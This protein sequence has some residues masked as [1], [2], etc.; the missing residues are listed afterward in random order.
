[1]NRLSAAAARKLTAFGMG[2]TVLALTAQPSLARP[3]ARAMTCGQ[4]QA[5]IAQQG[6]A[7]LTTGQHTFE[8]YVKN[9]N[10]C[11]HGEVLRTETIVTRDTNRCPVNKCIQFSPFH[12]D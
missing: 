5:T 6:A 12:F 4:V 9:R 1:M 11:Q 7:V 3:D 10:F 2:L 8:R